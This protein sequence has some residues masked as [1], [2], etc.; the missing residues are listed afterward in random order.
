MLLENYIRSFFFNICFNSDLFADVQVSIILSLDILHAAIEDRLDHLHC[1]KV[2][3]LWLIRLDSDRFVQCDHVPH[4]SL[5]VIALY[6][7]EF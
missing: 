3:R 7:Q 2:D 4:F 6:C 1:V 5:K